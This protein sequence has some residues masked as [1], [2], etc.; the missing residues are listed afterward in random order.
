MV[1]KVYA[2]LTY[3]PFFN[4]HLSILAHIHK[5][6]QPFW[7]KLG[8]EEILTKNLQRNLTEAQQNQEIN[9]LIASL[10]NKKPEFNQICQQ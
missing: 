9:Q 1:E 3:F 8:K 6:L 4:I 10:M 5:I 2:I 7:Y